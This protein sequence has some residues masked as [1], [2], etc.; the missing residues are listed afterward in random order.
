MASDK[1]LESAGFDDSIDDASAPPMNDLPSLSIRRPVL[2]LVVNL[3][4]LL[5]GLAALL[6]VEIRE[7]PDVDRPIVSVRAEYPGASPETMDAE[8]ISILEGA[9]ARVSGIYNIRSA[10][11]ENE[12][13]MRIEFQPNV[14]L[15]SAASD[16]RE[17][18]SRVMRRLP[19]RIEQVI[20]LK[21]DNDSDSIV[22]LAVLSDRLMDDEITRVIEKD[23][24]PELI[25][26]EGVADVQL[27]FPAILIALLID[28]SARA[29]L[30]CACG[31]ASVAECCG[32]PFMS[33][34]P[35]L[36]PMSD[37]GAPSAQTSHRSLIHLPNTSAKPN[38]RTSPPDW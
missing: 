9:V 23:I 8:V 38:S 24:V 22:N 36:R 6:S 32:L 28:G 20:I 13:R 5:A 1:D 15:D 25:S 12:G 30:P 11:E 35:G 19:D 18:V 29:M 27:S 14:D 10:S 26:I 31:C 4:V 17:A 37:C 7:L 34:S 2:V 16:V 33:G 21:A 3:L